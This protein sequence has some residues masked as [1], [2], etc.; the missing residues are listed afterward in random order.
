[1]ALQES[2]QISFA[3]LNFERGLGN[4]YT[5]DMSHAAYVYG[6]D[7]AGGISMDEFYGKLDIFYAYTGCGRGETA[8]Q[9]CSDTI[10]NRT[11]YS[12]DAAPNFGVGDYVYTDRYPTALSGFTD[13]YMNNDSWEVGPNGDVTALSNHEC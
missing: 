12:V 4:V 11:F 7:S 13:I 2:G 10:N 8:G 9:A 5:L 3:D 6:V 1:M